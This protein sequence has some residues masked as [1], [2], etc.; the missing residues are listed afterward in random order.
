[1]LNRMTDTT[2]PSPSNLDRAALPIM[3]LLLTIITVLIFGPAL[4]IP[5]DV[6][7]I[8]TLFLGLVFVVLHGYLS[9]GLR[10]FAVYLLLIVLISFTAEAV[11]VATGLIFGNYHYTDHLGPKILGVPPM[12]QVGY[13][14]MGYCSLIAARV[15]LGRQSTSRSS[16]ADPACSP[17]SAWCKFI[18]LALTAT[19]IMVAWDITMDPYQATISGDWL[20][21][22]GGPW[23]GIPIHNYIGWFGTV[24]TFTTAYLLFEKAVPLPPPRPIASSSLFWAMPTLFYAIMALGI[25]IVPF[26]HIYPA[27][28]NKDHFTGSIA[29]MQWSLT[30]LTFFTMGT[31]VLI[32][33]FRLPR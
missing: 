19:T 10:H 31:P 30:L 5:D 25:V 28:A 9:M 13:T 27:V 12:V 14:C 3:A 22:D 18:A 8:A 6:D 20:W 1:M 17:C 4:K 32:A 21:H 24:L 26:M 11:G 15:I 29:D 23:F 2:S 7:T 16:P 33:L